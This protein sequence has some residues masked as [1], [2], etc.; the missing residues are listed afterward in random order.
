MTKIK[1]TKKKKFSNVECS[2]DTLNKQ[3]LKTLLSIAYFRRALTQFEEGNYLG[4]LLTLDR[5]KKYDK[6]FDDIYSLRAIIHG[7]V[8]KDYNKAI[9]EINIGISLNP[10]SKKY[11]SLK[12]K[13]LSLQYG[14]NYQYFYI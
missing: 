8:L 12:N 11:N 10:N 6:S 9:Q 7:I 2:N 13:I 5:L 14:D 4:C 3:N 1:N